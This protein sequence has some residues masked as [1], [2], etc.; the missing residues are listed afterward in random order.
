MKAKEPTAIN[1][2]FLFVGE[3]KGKMQYL[4]YY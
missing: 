1:Q 4:N 3:S 2:L